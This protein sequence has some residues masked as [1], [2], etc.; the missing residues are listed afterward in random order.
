MISPAGSGKG[1]SEA[2]TLQAAAM[3][4]EL[5][6]RTGSRPSGTRFVECVYFRLRRSGE[7]G[8]LLTWRELTASL[9]DDVPFALRWQAALREVDSA[10]GG[11]VDWRIEGSFISHAGDAAAVFAAT[12]SIYHGRGRWEMFASGAANF[13][14]QIAE[15]DARAVAFDSLSRS[16]PSRLISPLPNPTGVGDF[17]TIA[18]W[19]RA[20]AVTVPAA[21]IAELWSLVGGAIRERVAQLKGAWLLTEGHAVPWMHLRLQ[22]P[23]D[24]RFLQWGARRSLEEAA[25]AAFN[26]AADDVAL[27]AVNF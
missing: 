24:F 27:S 3:I 12:S 7:G 21:Q 26:G 1:T 19:V 4:L 10:L 2:G 5:A 18:R 15:G 9:A 8:G 23:R 17:H 14:A 11:T 25:D 16:K 6:A 22:H 20:D 13:S